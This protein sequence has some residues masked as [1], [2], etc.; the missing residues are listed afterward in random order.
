MCVKFHIKSFYTQ[1]FCEFSHTFTQ[2]PTHTHEREKSHP[3]SNHFSSPKIRSFVRSHENWCTCTLYEYFVA[4]FQGG[5]G[6]EAIQ[7]WVQ[8]SASDGWQYSIYCH[9][10]CPYCCSLAAQCSSIFCTKFYRYHYCM[11]FAVLCVSYTTWTN[12]MTNAYFRSHCASK[13]SANQQIIW[14]PHVCYDWSPIHNNSYTVHL[15]YEPKI[16]KYVGLGEESERGRSA[17]SPN[18]MLFEYIGTETK[19]DIQ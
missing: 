14:L 17:Q 10:L 5:K 19:S 11:I 3:V 7:N 4:Q 2:T 13:R 12:Y 15:K 16:S 6:A 1:L 8:M 9:I 18:H